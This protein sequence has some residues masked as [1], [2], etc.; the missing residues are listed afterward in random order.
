[1]PTMLNAGKSL[2]FEAS[3]FNQIAMLSASGIVMSMAFV[4][5]GGV[6]ILYPWF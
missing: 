2:S 1:M 3:L 4:V 5:V 6:E